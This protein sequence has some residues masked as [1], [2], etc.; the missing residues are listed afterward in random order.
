MVAFVVTCGRENI[1]GNSKVFIYPYDT[2]TKAMK[3]YNRLWWCSKKLYRS[4]EGIATYGDEILTNWWIISPDVSFK[5]TVRK[6]RQLDLISYAWLQKMLLRELDET[7]EK[8]IL[9][10]EDPLAGE[11]ATPHQCADDVEL[12]I[13]S[14][15][16]QRKIGSKCGRSIRSG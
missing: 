4:I 15:G 5:E 10:W 14:G 2:M 13:L 6:R 11:W 8:K 12:T 1:T 3:Q 16:K 7:P 9:K